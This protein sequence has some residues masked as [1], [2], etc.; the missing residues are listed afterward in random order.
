[1]RRTLH[2]LSRVTFVALLCCFSFLTSCINDHCNEDVYTFLDVE[3]HSEIDTA[4]IASPI[5]SYWKGIGC[6]SVIKTIG[7]NHVNLSL[8]ANNNESMFHTVIAT[9]APET[10]ANIKEI[11]PDPNALFL[12]KE[13]TVVKCTIKEV[14][15]DIIYTF[16]DTSAVFLLIQ[17]Q[18]LEGNM[19][20]IM[21]N[22]ASDT[23]KVEYENTLEFVS[24]ECG[25]KNTFNIKDAYF[26]HNRVADAQVNNPIVDSE[27]YEKHIKLFLGGY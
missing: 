21:C 4:Q 10:F 6:D 20:Y 18:E 24:A 15:D 5:L 16:K 11:D 14:V 9:G 3:F 23:F 8:D 27:N 17:T 19:Y 12:F 2:R 25:C 1:M 13:T 22:A 26:M 7:L